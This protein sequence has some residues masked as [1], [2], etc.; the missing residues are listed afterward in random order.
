MEVMQCWREGMRRFLVQR[1]CDLHPIL[2]SSPSEKQVRSLGGGKGGPAWTLI[3]QT[4]L[5]KWGDT[6]LSGSS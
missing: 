2:D 1:K 6:H 5:V 4:P 3:S